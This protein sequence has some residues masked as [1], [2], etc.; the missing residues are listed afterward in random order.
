M[1][2][3]LIEL[4]VERGRLRERIGIQRAQLAREL[5][6]VVQAMHAMD[7]TRSRLHLVGQWMAAHPG[8]VAA[9]SVA[10]L[11][12]RPRAVLKTAGKGVYL[13]RNWARW[14]DWLRIGLRVL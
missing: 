11:V 5:E 10:V 6:P 7:R 13:W 8:I 9:V 12:W 1:D 2:A 14:R 3:R 4:Y